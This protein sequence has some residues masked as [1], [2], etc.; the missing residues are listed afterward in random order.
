M[1]DSSG[2]DPEIVRLYGKAQEAKREWEE[3][4]RAYEAAL[5]KAF[6]FKVGDVIKSSKG[7]VAR[8]ERIFCWYGRAKMVAVLRKKDGTFGVREASLWRQEWANPKI[9]EE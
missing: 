5:C 6:P 8:V 7:L 4:V 9:I 2:F 1:T 3:H